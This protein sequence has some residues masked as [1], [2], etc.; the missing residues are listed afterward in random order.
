MY[1]FDGV[2]V[3]A[4][5]ITK[6]GSGAFEY[7]SLT[8]I[9]F[10]SGSQLTVIDSFGFG[11]MT[12]LESLELPKSLKNIWAESFYNAAAL[13][14]IYYKGT[15]EEWD[16]INKDDDWNLY[17]MYEGEKGYLSFDVICSNGTIKV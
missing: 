3:V 14:T 1:G 9:K 12:G 11:I 4:D 8:Q 2:L 7:S 5:E 6:I 17:Y 16:A 10:R 13:R 15:M